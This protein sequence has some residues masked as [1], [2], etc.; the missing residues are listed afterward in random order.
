M[1]GQ[2]TVIYHAAN[3][4]QAHI[5]KGHLENAGIAAWVV[6][7]SPAMGGEE[8]PLSWTALSRV[9]V[10]ADDATDARQ[11][12]VAFDQAT[13][14]DPTPDE[15]ADEPEAAVWN[16]WPVCPQCQARR[17]VRCGICHSAG[18]EFALA[19]IFDRSE[20]R[21][22]K[23]EVLLIC[24]SCDD[25]FR[26]EMFR[27]CPECGYDYGDGLETE[28]ETAR[29]TVDSGLSNPRLWVVV[30]GLGAL[31]AAMAAYFYALWK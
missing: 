10:G 12:A 4:Q 28:T 30:G 31:A 19:S 23:V 13:S 18:T 9:V 3:P 6:N 17:S 7:D 16:E 8:S 27:L 1:S 15:A 14:H 2:P 20:G 29:S 21:G 11:M 24:P 26:P 25:H 22:G 5:L